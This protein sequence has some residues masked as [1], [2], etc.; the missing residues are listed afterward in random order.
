MAG[1]AALGAPWNDVTRYHARSLW[2][3]WPRHAEPLW[4][5]RRRYLLPRLPSIAAACRASEQADGVVV[6]PAWVAALLWD[7][8][9]RR[10][11]TEGLTDWALGR[12]GRD[13]SVGPYQ[14]TGGTAREVVRFLA[15]RASWA[16]ELALASTAE[17]R[18]RLLEFDLATRV[19]IGRCQQILT[20]WLAAG[21]D[22]RGER[23][24]GPHRV[25][26]IELI[27]TLYSQGLGRP[28]PNP[29]ANDRGAQIAGFAEQIDELAGWR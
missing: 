9:A 18:A 26:P 23:G 11:I 6:E 19:V 5:S 7:E 21:H 29:R 25:T 10:D 27:G 16:D 3:F 1:N 12:L 2:R 22:P 13:P 28:K 15:G 8:L 17:L 14:V 24:L 20:T 4:R